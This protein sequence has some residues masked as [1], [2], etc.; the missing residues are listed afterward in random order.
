VIFD[1]AHRLRNP[2]AQQTMACRSLAE[3]AK[4]RLF[5]SATAGQTPHELGYLGPLLGQAAGTDTGTLKGFRELMK[6][7]R[8]GRAKGRWTN[9][10]WEASDRDRERM[11]Q[12]LY[13]GP[14]AIG[15]RRRPEDIASWPESSVSWRRPC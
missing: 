4:F 1:E 14:R 7:L 2:Y 6:K 12:L 13:K 11:A 8:I 3:A 15:M 9:W 5:L 10:Q